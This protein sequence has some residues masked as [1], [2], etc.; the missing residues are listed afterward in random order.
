VPQPIAEGRRRALHAIPPASRAYSV[1]DHFS[2]LTIGRGGWGGRADDD[3][4]SS[5]SEVYGR[6]GERL[7]QDALVAVE[8]V[9]GT[10]TE[11]AV[12]ADVGD[13]LEPL[14]PL[15]IEIGV[16]QITRTGAMLFFQLMTRRHEQASTVLTSNR[17]FEDWGEIFGDD[18]MAAALIDRLVHHCHLVTIRGN[19]YPHAAAH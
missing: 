12:N 17:G 9:T 15:A 2:P 14:P 13:D 1:S 19:S 4:S 16:M 11:R 5:T 8:A 6:G 10:L 18:V 3:R 7:Q